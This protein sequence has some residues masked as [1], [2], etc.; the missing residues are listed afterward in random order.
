[1]VWLYLGQC[2]CDATVLAVAEFG[3]TVFGD[4]TYTW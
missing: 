4:V 2:L 1:M 3:M